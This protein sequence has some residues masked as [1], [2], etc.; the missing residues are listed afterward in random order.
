MNHTRQTTL[1]DKQH[2]R[3][4]QL[5]RAR[6]GEVPIPW[7]RR[8]GEG[9]TR[10]AARWSY[11][12]GQSTHTSRALPRFESKAEENLVE[13]PFVPVRNYLI[14]PHT[15]MERFWAISL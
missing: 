1:F 15:L 6:V 13:L 5:T 7:A 11:T 8:R 12:V 2:G 3:V 10:A 14:A 9:A 4:W